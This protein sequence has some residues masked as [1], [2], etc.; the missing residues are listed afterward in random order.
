MFRKNSGVEIFR[1]KEGGT[2]TF[3][4]NF[5]L[6]H[7]TEET[8]PGNHSVFQKNSGREKFSWIRG[9]GGLTIFRRKAF[10]SQ[11]RNEKF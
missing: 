7:R 3:L 1:A 5:F 11:Y 6:L 2:F 10:V 4:S 8:S 9:G